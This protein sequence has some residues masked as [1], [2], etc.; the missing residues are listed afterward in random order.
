MIHSIRL[1]RFKNFRDARLPLG[2]L[3]TL[4]GVNGSGKSNLR[5]AFRFLHGIA[6]GYNLSEILGEKYG[7]GGELQWRGIRGGIK[8]VAFDEE[9]KFSLSVTLD[10]S[11]SGR[12]LKAV[13]DYSICVGCEAENRPPR[14][15]AESLAIDGEK[16]FET[17]PGLSNRHL[18]V[19]YWKQSENGTHAR[20]KTYFSN[21]PVLGQLS[22]DLGR[23]SRAGLEMAAVISSLGSLRFLDL[24]PSAMRK[25]SLPGQDVLGDQGENLS[26]V[27]LQICEDPQRKATLLEWVNELTPMD[28]VDFE[29]PADQV[30]RVLLTLVEEGGRRTSAYSASDGTLRFLAMIAALLGPEASSFYF[31]EELEN[32]IHP[33][34][35]ALL[36]DLIEKKV[37]EGK[38]QVVA[39]S[40]SPFFLGFLS[41]TALEYAS[42]IYRTEGRADARIKRIL[43]IPD[44]QRLIREQ[45]LA[46]LHV[47]GWFEDAVEFTDEGAEVAG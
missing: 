46:R 30:G 31:F 28:C 29:F 32:G 40:H 22:D 27:L 44:A 15:I 11:D 47:S 23:E 13:A 12:L 38:I 9:K 18:G 33:A 17:R 25:P 5:D 41:P 2:P 26:S 20:P 7:E 6:R 1:V 42:L 10:L 37:S 24:S 35:L 14:V 3:T 39:S 19:F 8:E 34:R 43:D 16:V 45:N 21:A 36:L 4:I